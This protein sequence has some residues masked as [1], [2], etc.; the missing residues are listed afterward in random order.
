MSNPQNSGGNMNRKLINVLLGGALA[1]GATAATAQTYRYVDEYTLRLGRAPEW[2][3]S[4]TGGTCRLRIWVDDK[5]DVQMRGDQ[6][7]VRTHSGRRSFD[8]GS[9]C[10]QPLPFHRVDDFRV[11]AE[12]G[13]GNV[14]DV[15]PPNRRNNFTST[16]TIDDPQPGGETYDVVVAW[17]NPE[18]RRID[19][20]ASNDPFPYFDETRACQERVRA[21][22]LRR[23]EEAAYIEFMT[24]TF[25]DEM[26]PNRERIRGEAWVRN[27][28]E[29]RPMTYECVLNERNDRV[30]SASYEVR[31]PARVS[32]LR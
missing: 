6:I 28:Y 8:Q 18:G 15:N 17:R 14:F 19:P 12:R 5:A 23:N 20:V 1:L 32:S 13:R 7:L 29:S 16:I 30:L 21:D 3:L 25:R 24:G 26:G 27:R 11:V 4:A 2:D 22:F 10:N 9:V 31:G